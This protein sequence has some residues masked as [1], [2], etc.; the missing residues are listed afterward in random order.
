MKFN[1]KTKPFNHQ[2]NEITDHG[3]KDARG[4]FWEPG[5]GKTKPIV[6]CVSSL[7]DA[8]EINGLIVI[9]PNG[10]HR[11]WLSDEIPAHMPDEIAERLRGHIW[12]STKTKAHV[13][14]FNDTLK[15]DGLATLVMS[16]EAVRTELGLKAWKAFLKQRKCTYVL[17]ES[18][19]IK[20]P[21]T[22]ISKRI[23]G[24]KNAA[25]FKRVLS[26]TPCDN[27]PFDLYN[28][29]RFLK[30]DI[31]YPLGI[32]TFSA[33]KNYFGIFETMTFNDR[34]F[35]QCVA[36]KNLHVLNEIL[37]SMG[38]RVVK[39]D[40]LDLPPQLYSKRYVKLTSQ[41]KRMYQQLK[42]DFYIE[43]ATGDV[44]AAL[45]IVR[46]LRFQQIICG[47][48]PTSDDD[49][50][51][52]EVPGGNPRLNLLVDTCEGIPHSCIIWA[53]FTKDIELI[54]NH[55]F[56]KNNCVVVNGSVT[57]PARGIAI[58]R[59][60]NKEV[61]FLIANPAA[62]SEGVTLTVAQTAIYYSNSFKLKDRI[63]SEARPHRAGQ[64][65]PVNYI[66]LVAE[67]TIDTHIIKALKRKV[68]IA[69]QVTGD[70]VGE[71]I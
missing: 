31:W 16:Y 1:F 33:F 54:S 64:T 21:G 27:S 14:S 12:Y 44:S 68:N 32:R 30:E 28:Q 47:Y 35:Q 66:D 20:T 5:T 6:D 10:V 18:H 29:L 50:T 46:L 2:L 15:H 42:D 71:W 48:L 63:Q 3:E 4:L 26:G 24:S 36:Y 40:V 56:F 23:M 11:N 59:F 7:Y 8:K 43:Q 62:L 25:P 70:T 57:G 22:K 60:K 69:S 37:H 9:A 67:D 34:Q 19:R 61:Q 51:L 53:R 52:R 41:Q 45:A 39:S 58:D 55:K 49:A 65:N 13:N 38:S 17:D